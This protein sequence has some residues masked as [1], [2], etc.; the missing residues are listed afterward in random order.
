MVLNAP[1]HT[2]VGC[3][4]LIIV[5]HPSDWYHL[6]GVGC[7]MTTFAM[8][9]IIP[10]YRLSLTLT[11]QCD[12]MWEIIDTGWHKVSQSDIKEKYTEPL[13][14]ELRE[15]I[16]GDGI[17]ELTE[18]SRPEGVGRNH[19][20][21][22]IMGSFVNKIHKAE[23][24][25]PTNVFNKELK[26]YWDVSLT[27]LSKS[28]KQAHGDWVVQGDPVMKQIAYMLDTN[29]VSGGLGGNSVRE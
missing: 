21:N 14:H 23:N 27:L 6:C 10:Q 9:Q 1:S 28:S 16:G 20:I 7:I 2:M 18:S 4:I 13:E 26:P 25:I 19:G 22:A 12:L 24:D 17:S 8:Y 11:R 29:N 3:L 15:L 5:L